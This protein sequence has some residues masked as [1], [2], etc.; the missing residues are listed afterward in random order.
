M[1]WNYALMHSLYADISPN[2]TFKRRNKEAVR[3]LLY[4]SNLDVFW[5]LKIFPF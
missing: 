2:M 3:A 4:F 5:R 1:Y